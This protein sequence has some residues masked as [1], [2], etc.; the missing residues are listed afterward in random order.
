[1]PSSI[2]AQM[3]ARFRTLCASAQKIEWTR[4]RI[5][6]A[7]IGSLALVY[8]IVRV[9]TADSVLPDASDA[10]AAVHMYVA[11]FVKGKAVTPS[12]D[13]ACYAAAR[14]SF[15]QCHGYEAAGYICVGNMC[16]ATRCLGDCG[17]CAVMYKP[18]LLDPTTASCCSEFDSSGTCVEPRSGLPGS[19]IPPPP[20]PS[21]PPSCFAAKTSAFSHCAGYE[22]AGYTCNPVDGT[23]VC[24]APRCLAACLDCAV[25][26]MGAKYHAKTGQCCTAIGAGPN[27]KCISP[28]SGVPGDDGATHKA[29]LR[30]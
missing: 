18:A 7:V 16:G 11:S 13:S 8:F 21:T 12:A 17:M 1:M 27:G 10:A 20:S 29:L 25:E 5:L 2:F 14:D 4:G 23:S 24:A 22:A 19:N 3:L 15:P 28:K 9:L 26:Y 30:A 6:L